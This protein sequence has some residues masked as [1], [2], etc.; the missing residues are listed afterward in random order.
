MTERIGDLNLGDR[1][2]FRDEAGNVKEMLD[3]E[4]GNSFSESPLDFYILLARYKFAMRLIEKGKNV[5]DAGCGMGYGSMMLASNGCIVT[6][7]DFDEDLIKANS[8]R[9]EKNA[10]LNFRK[11]DLLNVPT[12]LLGKFDSVVSMDV[13][14]HFSKEQV[15]I[16]VGNYFDL[17]GADGFAVIGTPHVK[18]RPYASAR[19]LDTHPFEFEAA[20]F[21]ACLAKKFK[22]V[23]LFSMTDETVSTQFLP[24]SWYLMA[25]CTK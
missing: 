11:L 3:H 12:D 18:S 4:E 13:I 5:L 7:G 25:V 22:N 6:G 10:N 21:K 19:R 2:L 8:I 15:N 9:Y 24:L 16:V 23:F 1:R 14:E 17:L 20:E